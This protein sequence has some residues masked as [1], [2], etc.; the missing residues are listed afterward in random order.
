MSYFE[1]RGTEWPCRMCMSKKAKG[2]LLAGALLAASIAAPS[3]AETAPKEL[4]I[5]VNGKNIG[6]EMGTGYIENDRTMVPI[7]VVSE[8]LGFGVTWD[9]E[10]RTVN[11]GNVDQEVLLTIDSPIARVNGENKYIDDNRNVKAIIQHDR[12]YLPLRFVSENLGAKVDYSKNAKQNI[13]DITLGKPNQEANGVLDVEKTKAKS[14]LYRKGETDEAI[15]KRINQGYTTNDPAMGATA[16][17]EA[18][19]VVLPGKVSENWIAPD[20]KVGYIDPFNNSMNRQVPWG[21]LIKNAEELHGKNATVK[22]EV[23]D[24]RYT[25]TMQ[26]KEADGNW[27]SIDRYVDQDPYKLDDMRNTSMFGFFPYYHL[28]STNRQYLRMK[29]MDSLYAPYLG[30]PI[31]YKVTFTQDGETH[32]YEFLIRYGFSMTDKH[33]NEHIR[34]EQRAKHK[35]AHQQLNMYKPNATTQTGYPFA[36]KQVQ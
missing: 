6:T 25:G 30:D 15:Q 11:V 33:L 26:M 20:F 35:A 5:N 7:R 14:A 4:I 12:T 19:D 17:Q 16:E 13:V 27:R 36:W 29:G 3:R 22:V 2:L 32:A 8:R 31:K 10:A 18:Q 1:R 23:I 9:K 34:P 28:N 21:F 24:D